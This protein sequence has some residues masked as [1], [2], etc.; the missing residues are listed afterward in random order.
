MQ[1]LEG[2]NDGGGW[3][4][5]C[6]MYVFTNS[7]HFYLPVVWLEHST[8]AD[9][10]MWGQMVCDWFLFSIFEVNCERYQF[11]TWISLQHAKHIPM[12]QSIQIFMDERFNRE[13][14]FHLPRV[15]L[16]VDLHGGSCI[17]SCWLCNGVYTCVLSV[18]LLHRHLKCSWNSAE[19]VRRTDLHHLVLIDSWDFGSSG[20]IV[21]WVP[22]P[23]SVAI[24]PGQSKSHEYGQS[25]SMPH[26]P[27]PFSLKGLATLQIF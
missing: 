4:W 15:D 12:Q 27:L 23:S 19:A 3:C 17:F 7:H 14:S 2:D 16:L 5:V 26:W 11:Q 22:L 18:P 25:R 13:T 21:C 24:V 6:C 9:V 8:D 20:G 10:W 1:I